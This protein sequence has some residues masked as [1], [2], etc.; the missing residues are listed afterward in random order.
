MR[1]DDVPLSA[2]G[3]CR[4]CNDPVI[5]TRTTRDKVMPVDPDPHPA[6]TL[7]LLVVDR[8]VSAP[9]FVRCLVVPDAPSGTERDDLHRSHFVTCPNADD[10]R[11]PR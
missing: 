11:R 2:R 8:G 4:S 7:D 3:S 6:G 1:R 10:H 5:W 9:K